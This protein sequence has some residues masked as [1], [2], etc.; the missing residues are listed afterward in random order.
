MKQGPMS[1]YLSF[2][3]ILYKHIPSHDV[4]SDQRTDV[5]VMDNTYLVKYIPKQIKVCH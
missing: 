4:D 1:L 3:C 5:S 2:R